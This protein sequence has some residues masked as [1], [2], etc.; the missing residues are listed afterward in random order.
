MKNVIAILL[1]LLLAVGGGAWYFTSFRMDSMIQNRIESL[2]SAS[3]ETQV[4]VGGVNTDIKGGALSI[5]NI[6]IAN[7]PGF[8]NRN[9]LS[10]NGIEAVIDYSNFEIKRLVIDKPDIVIEEKDGETNFSR[11]MA[12]LEKQESDPE[13]A[14][15]GE[16]EPIIVIHFFRMNESRAAFES[17]S[18]D[19][20]SDLK[21]D[22]VELTNIKGTRAEVGKVIAT[23]IIKEITREA[24]TE[25]LKAKASEKLGGLFRKKKD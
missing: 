8:D 15:G 9:A 18:L 14:A 1:V 21:I 2:A 25:M 23:A 10:L 24:A 16:E 13:P 22:A 4:S 3:L 20:Y 19:H 12:G 11:M 7:P 17:K 6:T 5:S